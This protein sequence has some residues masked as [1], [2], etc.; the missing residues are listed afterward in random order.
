MGGMVLALRRLHLP[1]CWGEA[2]ASS[3][4]RAR[5]A[6]LGEQRPLPCSLF[7]WC[8]YNVLECSLSFFGKFLKALIQMQEAATFQCVGA[9]KAQRP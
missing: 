2:L 1:F 3:S 6:S 7:E 4:G 9:V 5:L 8:V